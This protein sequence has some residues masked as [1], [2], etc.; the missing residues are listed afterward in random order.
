MSYDLH[1]AAMDAAYDHWSEELYP[2]HRDQAI[3]EFR[4]KRLRSYYLDHKDLLVPAARNFRSAEALSRA[5]HSAAAIVFA[6]SAVELFLK[7]CL[8]RPVVAGL[9]HSETLAN[10]LVES[11]LSQTGF[12][13]Y[14]KLLT[15]LFKDLADQD[16]AKIVRVGA[17]KPLLGEI[18]AL[19]QHRND[20]AHDG[21]D[22]A[23]EQAAVAVSIARAVFDEVLAVVLAK[24]GVTVL[25]GGGLADA[26]VP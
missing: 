22:A 19:Q 12:K 1:D 2:E 17:S 25:P 21:S 11:A 20:I 6:A 26:E 15:A 14:M 18:S 3:A 5:G 9:V 10:V 4:R 13:R 8:L 23:P 16:I 24:L 7:A